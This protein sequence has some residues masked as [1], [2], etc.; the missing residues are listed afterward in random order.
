[1][2]ATLTFPKAKY[3]TAGITYL[4]YQKPSIVAWWSAVFPGFGHYLLNQYARATLL[5][6]LEVIINT[7]ANINEAMVYSFCG[8][9]ELAKSV[10]HLDW[11]IGYI[12]I[13]LITIG[14]SYRSAVQLN[15]YIE[16]STPNLASLEI[17]PFEIQYLQNKSPLLGVF[18]SLF[19]PGLGQLYNH[20]IFLG[21]YAIFWWWVYI[22]LSHAHKAIIL[23]ITGD[24]ASSTAILHPHW[25]LFM[26]SVLGGAVYHS[27][28][29]CIH[30]NILAKE[31]QQK[32]LTDRYVGSKLN[33]RGVKG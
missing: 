29:T 30:H 27:Y 21:F 33:I 23:T 28:I 20:R 31:S 6:V 13:Y 26:P 9:I 16:L 2:S 14:D 17:F 25:L 1:M 8:E 19:F 11:M 3:S 10:I 32:R 5:T 12:V 4:M 7:G 18:Y 24:F 15:K 22:L